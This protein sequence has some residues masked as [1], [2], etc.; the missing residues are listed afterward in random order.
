[1]G[2]VETS[3][4]Y[5]S[6][7][8]NSL[9]I[10]HDL[11]E[12]LGN[13]ELISISKILEKDDKIVVRKKCIG[14]VF[15]VYFASI[16][17]V[18]KRFIEKIDFEHVEYSFVVIN[19]G[20]LYGSAL[21]EFD[22]MLKEKEVVLNSG[23][24]VNMP[25]NHPKIA[26]LFKFNEE[27]IFIKKQQ[28]ELKIVKKIKQKVNIKVESNYGILGY[29]STYVFF[30]K[31]QKLSERGKLDELFNVSNTCDGCGLCEKMCPVQNI[32]IINQVPIWNHHCVNCARCFHLCPKESIEFGDETMKQYIN[33]FIKM[34]ELLN[35]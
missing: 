23:F 6:G 16:P 35:E 18:V 8:G 28:K 11:E 9:N 2:I 30:R 3:I 4:Y 24:T 33:P 20:G 29:L 13:V 31:L 34:D 1:M 21:K 27:E 15:P 26:K 25:G 32:Q 7:T 5:F 14:F 19:G 10:A 17:I 22:K 12:Q